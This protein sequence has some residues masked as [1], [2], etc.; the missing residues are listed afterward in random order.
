MRLKNLK[1]RGDILVQL[2]DEQYKLLKKSS[3]DNHTI[4]VCLRFLV[5][6][7]FVAILSFG[8][9]STYLNGIAKLKVD[10]MRAEQERDMAI[11]KAENDIYVRKIEMGDLSFDE[12]LELIKA[13]N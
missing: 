3:D 11:L 7:I 5:L 2:S 10:Y 9:L 6:F 12:Y 13:Q 8:P 4:V 1:I